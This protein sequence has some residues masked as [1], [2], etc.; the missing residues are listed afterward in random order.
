[1]KRVRLVKTAAPKS[2]KHCSGPYLTNHTAPFNSLFLNA[3]AGLLL[4][5]EIICT[6][7][8]PE[9]HFK[10]EGNQ[11]ICFLLQMAEI[12]KTSKA[13]NHSSELENSPGKSSSLQDIGPIYHHATTSSQQSRT[14]HKG[15]IRGSS[16]GLTRPSGLSNA[17]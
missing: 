9:I 15:P 7:Y 5:F 14:Q 16:V 11:L 3:P 6:S 13:I 12:T 1:M 2:S 4:T 17:P 8:C 10:L